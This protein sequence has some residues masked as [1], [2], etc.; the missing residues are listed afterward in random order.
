MSDPLKMTTIPEVMTDPLAPPLDPPGAPLSAPLA[1]PRPEEAGYVRDEKSHL[2][3]SD[4]LEKQLK[5]ELLDVAGNV[6]QLTLQ[7][8]TGSLQERAQ[9]LITRL[10]NAAQ[11]AEDALKRAARGS[12]P[13][14]LQLLKDTL[15]AERAFRDQA[16]AA[17]GSLMQEVREL[18]KTAQVRPPPDY[19][20]SVCEVAT[21]TGHD[22]DAGGV[23]VRHTP[24]KKAAPRA[25]VRKAP[26]KAEAAP[27]KDAPKAAK[28]TP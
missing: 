3:T 26:A 9:A 20:R 8:P 14:A 27:A 4:E 23:Q 18:H 11:Q 1:P 15:E 13:E 22:I 19:V 16:L 25:R 12:A 21:A 17:M 10:E 2:V 24:Q 7:D 6:Q 28:E 5:A